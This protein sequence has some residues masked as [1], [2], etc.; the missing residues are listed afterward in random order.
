MLAY[1]TGV[2]LQEAEI[3]IEGNINI[4]RKKERERERERRWGGGAMGV[5][6]GGWSAEGDEHSRAR[7]RVY[8]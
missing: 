3:E 2:E 7:G 8:E 4:Q 1:L 5:D 6:L